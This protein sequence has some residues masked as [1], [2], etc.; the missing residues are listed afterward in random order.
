MSST[1]GGI[2]P[3]HC[4]FSPQRITPSP[5]STCKSWKT[6]LAASTSRRPGA[7]WNFISPA[8]TPRPA[9]PTSSASPRF[10]GDNVL[11]RDDRYEIGG[12]ITMNAISFG[13]AA[14]VGIAPDEPTPD[15]SPDAAVNRLE[16]ANDL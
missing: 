4:F 8:S 2:Q 12:D 1:Y 15:Q 11:G 13:A 9:I 6:S 14:C 7:F 10:L 16:A 5:R 3:W